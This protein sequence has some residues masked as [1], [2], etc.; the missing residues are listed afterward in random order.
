[1][2]RFTTKAGIFYTALVV[3][4]FSCK[5]DT[6]QSVQN[7]A[8]F[9]SYIYAYTS[10]VISKVAPVK[11]QFSVPVAEEQGGEEVDA[12]VLRIKPSV[13]GRVV[14][15]DRQTLVF[16]PEEAFAS[17]Q[18]YSA[19][20]YMTKLF[21]DLPEDVRKFPFQFRVKDQFMALQ[22]GG[23][24]AEDI[25][26]PNVQ[27]YTGIIITNDVAD[28]EHVEQSLTAKQ[29][30]KN[31]NVTWEHNEDNRNH[32]FTIDGIERK[33]NDS[34]LTLYWDGKVIGAKDKGV[35]KVEIP[36]IDNFKIT[37]ARVALGEN[38][39]H[40]VLQFSD[41][42]KASQ[43]LTGLVQMDNY[44]GGFRYIV[45]GQQVRLY[46][47]KRGITG[48][49]K[50]KVS[51]KI[52]N[53]NGKTMSNAAEWDVTFREVK[54]QVRLVGNGVI[55]PTSDGLVFPFE[56]VGLTDVEVE[57]HKVFNN[58]ILQ[59]LQTNTL[60]GNGEME[61]VGRII[62]QKR[63]SLGAVNSSALTGEWARY[64]LNLKDLIDED[65]DAIYQVVIGFRP[66]YSTFN[67]P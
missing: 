11:I 17:G 56:A 18:E 28:A 41:P 6:T 63:V 24:Q 52:K 23:L 32:T 64:A 5:S 26:N 30:N 57:I 65:P 13:K 50:I 21:K 10:G 36:A 47:T 44:N 37:D 67:C 7:I 14:W 54:P 62:L 3:F 59:F 49:R 27:Q 16:E 58:N 25:S 42:L 40:I 35:E 55:V 15:E 60:E 29:N 9:S 53:F 22:S 39:Q 66:E 43:D 61:R 48:T 45:E 20:L 4:L 31:L 1:M 19:T 33:N 8:N 12:A 51:G 34:E 38:E 46:P 2:T